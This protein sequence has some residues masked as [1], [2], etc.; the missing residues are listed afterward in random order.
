[1][2]PNI[3]NPYRY[4]S[5]CSPSNDFDILSEWT[6]STIGS[7]ASTG[8]TVPLDN[9]ARN[10][11]LITS[12]NWEFSCNPV[13]STFLGNACNFG[14]SRTDIPYDKSEFQYCWVLYS[15]GTPTMY[16][17]YRQPD[18]SGGAQAGITYV[19][20]AIYSIK[21]VSGTVTF[22][23]NGALQKQVPVTH[24]FDPSLNTHAYFSA[25][26]SAQPSQAVCTGV[27][28]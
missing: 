15:A 19:T 17:S 3:F 12:L 10:S 20:N 14:I 23:I 7:I 24:N 21:C 5:G 9:Y 16:W 6:Q 28:T 25:G 11:C 13:G 1:M 2:T 22:N 27:Q 18:G 8:T 4:V 26:Q